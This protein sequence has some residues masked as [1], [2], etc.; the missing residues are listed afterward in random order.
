VPGPRRTRLPWI[1]GFL[2]LTLSVV[3]G[4]FI[5]LYASYRRQLEQEL[6]QRLIAV[7]SA[8][9]A[10]VNGPVWTGLARGDTAT[11]AQVRR[12]LKEIQEF[13]GVSD[14]FIFDTEQITLFDLAGRYEVGEENLAL[15]I[16][17]VAAVTQ[18]LAGL[19]AATELYSSQGGYLKSGYAPILASDAAVVGGVGVEASATFFEVLGQVRRTLLGAALVVGVGMVLLAVVLAQ[20]LSAQERL[21]SRLRRTETLATMGQMAAMLAHEVRN[22]LGII[23]GAAERI[24]ERF[25]I[26]DDEV[27]RF[28]PE[29]VDRL[30]RTLGA[31]L[32]FARPKA[33]GDVSDVRGALTRTL[34]LME[35]ELKRKGIRLQA[36]MEEGEFP[37]R[38]D[39][40][41]LQQAFLNLL[42]NA[43]DAMKEGQSL[44]VGLRRSGN[45]TEVSVADTGTGMTSEVRRRAAEPFYTSKQKGS[46]LG[47]AVVN[48]VMTDLGGRMRIESRPGRG[49]VVTLS[50]PRAR[51]GERDE[52][53][54]GR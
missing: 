52:G 11:V 35:P 6:G 53:D 15:L 50:L 39:A 32:D 40:H 19:P 54:R 22:P 34:D 26:Q 8:S 47:L 14:I 28:I 49:T 3:Y 48:R 17:D 45:R 9:A 7:A 30:E 51:E 21:Q 16:A 42:L 13:N 25:H 38:G 43:R 46:G 2:L 36:D 41:L 31:Y 4:A 29:E 5:V 24:G 18:A 20:L 12:E 33:V 1:L 10:A 37:V 23:R 44:M 27:Y